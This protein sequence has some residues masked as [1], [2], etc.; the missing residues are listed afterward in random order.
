MVEATRYVGISL[1]RT[2]GR[3]T[4]GSSGTITAARAK[5]CTVTRKW[6][7]TGAIRTANQFS[8]GARTSGFTHWITD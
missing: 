1:I 7:T 6:V 2:S 4:S 8:T 5:T 3:T